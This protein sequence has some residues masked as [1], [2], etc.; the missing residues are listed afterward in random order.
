VVA[1]NYSKSGY[2]MQ[3]QAPEGSKSVRDKEWICQDLE[4]G[5]AES[6]V[7]FLKR[8]QPHPPHH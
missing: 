1:L 2:S 5:R 3:Q 4:A 8:E 6:G 7:G